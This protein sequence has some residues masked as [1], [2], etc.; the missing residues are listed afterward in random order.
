MGRCNIKHPQ[1]SE[2]RCWSTIVNNWVSEWMPE[3]DYKQWLVDEAAR[4][5]QEDIEKF[6]I[7]ESNIQTY[8]ECVYELA[9]EEHCRNC[10]FK[11]DSC[12]NCEYNITVEDY[13]KQGNDYFNLGLKEKPV[14][15]GK[16]NFGEGEF[17]EYSYRG[18]AIYH[19]Y[20][21]KDEWIITE[22]EKQYNSK[23]EAMKAIDDLYE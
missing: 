17:E 7:K 6:G 10:R 22:G 4:I 5:E 3:E 12:D 2:W 16:Y 9:L 14:F 13:I 8:D 21:G 18:Q 1:T 23:E 19:N 20:L 11:Y 15:E